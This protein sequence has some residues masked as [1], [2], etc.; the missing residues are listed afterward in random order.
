VQSTVVLRGVKLS[1]GHAG[2][3]DG[4][5]SAF[6]D[7]RYAAKPAA[8]GEDQKDSNAVYHPGSLVMWPAFS[9]TTVDRRIALGYG[10]S[11][12]RPMKD[13]AVIF[14][15]FARSAKPIKEFS[16]YPFEEELLYGPNTTFSV[17]G[18][19]EASAYNPC[20]GSGQWDPVRSP[21]RQ[22]G[23]SKRQ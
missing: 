10:A 8:E 5:V 2:V 20:G 14:K 12:L 1:F 17:H 6:L 18:L 11:N 16:Y 3:A 13:A 19:W 22:F 15:I 9:S 7:G 23:Y 21:R 4:T